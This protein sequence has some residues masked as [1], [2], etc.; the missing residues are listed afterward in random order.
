MGAL[1]VDD[2]AALAV[3]VHQV[4]RT[5]ITLQQHGGAVIIRQ[6]ALEIVERYPQ[7]GLDRSTRLG[8]A[9][10]VLDIAPLMLAR[11]QHWPKTRQLERPGVEAMPFGQMADEV[12][13]DAE[14]LF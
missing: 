7:H 2:G 5:G 9:L 4:A 10:H 8:S 1:P 12:L 14:L 6:S 13:R 3:L 11:A